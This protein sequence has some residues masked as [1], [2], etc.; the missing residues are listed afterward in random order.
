MLTKP[1]WR[2]IFIQLTGLLIITEGKEKLEIEDSSRKELNWR[3][4]NLI[5]RF[6]KV[7]WWEINWL[8]EESKVSK[9]IID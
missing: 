5:E 6:M 3:P 2:R 9:V 4:T 1:L 7:Y 8:I